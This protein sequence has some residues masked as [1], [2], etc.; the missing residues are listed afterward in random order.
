MQGVINAAGQLHTTSTL[1]GE[2]ESTQLIQCLRS[3]PAPAPIPLD[4]LQAALEA[5]GQKIMSASGSMTISTVDASEGCSGTGSSIEP[6]ATVVTVLMDELEHW[7][8]F[9][10]QFGVVQNVCPIMTIMKKALECNAWISFSIGCGSF[11][12]ACIT[13][14]T[15]GTTSIKVLHDD[16]SSFVDTT[17]Q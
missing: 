7:H 10:P 5:K 4:A 17:P 12:I 6:A 16:T 2:N 9:F 15:V 13:M 1:H 14:L 11:A 3:L 8:K